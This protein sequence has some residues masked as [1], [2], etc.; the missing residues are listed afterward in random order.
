[1]YSRFLRL[2][3]EL[4]QYL[5][6]HLNNIARKYI[7]ILNTHLFYIHKTTYI[8][9]NSVHYFFF[10]I[11]LTNPIVPKKT[12]LIVNPPSIV[13][14]SIPYNTYIYSLD[15]LIFRAFHF[16]CIFSS[17]QRAILCLVLSARKKKNIKC[18]WN[19]KWKYFNQLCDLKTN[20]FYCYMKNMN[21]EWVNNS[22]AKW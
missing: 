5:Q 8:R 12:A 22:H 20:D 15:N 9:T 10:F 19:M 3:F 16:F 1:M 7:D 21:N 2:H 4:Y 13:W 18:R 14:L 6:H 17:I 11:F